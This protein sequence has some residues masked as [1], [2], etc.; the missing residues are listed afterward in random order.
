M[1]SVQGQEMDKKYQFKVHVSRCVR[2][3]NLNDFSLSIR[4]HFQEK[5]PDTQLC[6]IR[7]VLKIEFNISLLSRSVTVDEK[8]N[9]ISRKF[10]IEVDVI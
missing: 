6:Q 10:G 5:G 9:L 8:D 2:E 3:T 7:N 1:I 4:K